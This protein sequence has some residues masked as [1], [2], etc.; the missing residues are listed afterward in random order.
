MRPCVSQW[1]CRRKLA[2]K[3]PGTK[4]TSAI[5]VNVPLGVDLPLVGRLCET[6]TV[7]HSVKPEFIKQPVSLCRLSLWCSYPVTSVTTEI[8]PRCSFLLIYTQGFCFQA[9][10]YLYGNRARTV[11]GTDTVHLLPQLV[12]TCLGFVRSS[13]CL[14]CWRAGL[15]SSRVCF[16]SGASRIACLCKPVPFG[17]ASRIEWYSS[18]AQCVTHSV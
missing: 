16:T 3:R 12:I 13:F 14:D 4:L 7:P 9:E 2:T 17:D 6:A 11:T 8:A 15:W 1:V 10:I 5:S 18:G